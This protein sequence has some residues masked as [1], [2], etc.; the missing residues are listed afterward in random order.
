MPNK[1]IYRTS[2]SQYSSSR[3]IDLPKENSPT[4]GSPVRGDQ[5]H[6]S[7]KDF[8]EYIWLHGLDNYN[9]WDSGRQF[10]YWWSKHWDL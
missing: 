7:I 8:C 10:V 3:I 2:L 1:N 9:S 4:S 5:Y 6:N